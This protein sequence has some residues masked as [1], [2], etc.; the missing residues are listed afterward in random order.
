[1]WTFL[2][3]PLLWIPLLVVAMKGLL[4][5]DA[6]VIFDTGW[7]VAN[8]LIGIGVIPLMLWVSK[9]YGDRWHHWSWVQT[10]MDDIAGRNLKKASAFL[11]ELSI[12]EREVN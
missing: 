10:L 5:L 9:R 12:F 11:E 7:L 8:A 3:A 4:G 1:M 6:Y 2:L